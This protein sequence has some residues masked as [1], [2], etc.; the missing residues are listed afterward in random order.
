MNT[1]KKVKKNK[2][3][4]FWNGKRKDNYTYCYNKS[5]KCN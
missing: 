2:E 1:I 3:N 4:Y 5:F